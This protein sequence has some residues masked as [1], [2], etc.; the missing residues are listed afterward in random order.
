[1]ISESEFKLQ[2]HT[3][4]K[5][6]ELE[7]I[8]V[9]RLPIL[10]L[11]EITEAIQAIC[12][13][14]GIKMRI[15]TQTESITS[16]AEK[17][18]KAVRHRVIEVKDEM[19]KTDTY[20]RENINTVENFII[21]NIE[22]LE[23]TLDELD[24]SRNEIYVN[25]ED[26][27]QAI[28]EIEDRIN[29]VYNEQNDRLTPEII[30]TL[31]GQVSMEDC[32][33]ELE[34][35]SNKIRLL[36]DEIKGT[37]SYLIYIENEMQKKLLRHDNE[38]KKAEL[39][40]MEVELKSQ[41]DQLNSIKKDEQIM[42]L[43]K[44]NDLDTIREDMEKALAEFEN[45]KSKKT[46]AKESLQCAEKIL[47]QK[48]FSLGVNRTYESSRSRQYDSTLD[49]D[50]R[51]DVENTDPNLDPNQHQFYDSSANVIFQSPVP[52]DG[53]SDEEY[54]DRDI[55]YREVI[56][57]TKDTPNIYTGYNKRSLSRGGNRASQMI[58]PLTESYDCQNVNLE[59]YNSMGNLGAK[60]RKKSKV[61]NSFRQSNNGTANSMI[62]NLRVPA[63]NY[64]F[65]EPAPDYHD[66]TTSFIKNIQTTESTRIE[67]SN[68][69][70]HQKSTKMLIDCLMKQLNPITAYISD[71]NIKNKRNAEERSRN[72]STAGSRFLEVQEK[73]KGNNNNHLTCAS[74]Q[75]VKG[76]HTD[77]LN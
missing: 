7:T 33:K 12:E 56:L 57:D 14:M 74:V 32:E 34:N 27:S 68:L 51:Y 17:R 21:P 9:K 40:K 35:M 63:S 49:F 65:T 55:H 39:D 38:K 16:K 22:A 10:T 48:R 59:R 64:L 18:L 31:D 77:M 47:N 76:R 61:R 15:K 23:C 69:K 58:N 72:D 43:E 30:K 44:A 1:M 25:L 70:N 11:D 19:D 71:M 8:I 50:T 54:D 73:V 66:S 67:T 13:S 3:V 46:K 20:I 2:T 29:D 60:P 45:I 6:E 24:S 62:K 75:G 36:E 37:V 52:E 41:I 53:Y 42:M 28:E 4:D 5:L 26:V